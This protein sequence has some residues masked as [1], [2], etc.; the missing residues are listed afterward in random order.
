[1][2]MHTISVKLLIVGVIVVS[3]T[4]TDACKALTDTVD[5]GMCCPAQAANR[6]AGSAFA[7]Q[8]HFQGMTQKQS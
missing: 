2:R 6:H 5:R 3:K 8:G 4:K 1:M 7:L